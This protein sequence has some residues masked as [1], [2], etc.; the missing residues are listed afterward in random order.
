MLFGRVSSDDDDGL[1]TIGLG[2]LPRNCGAGCPYSPG[3]GHPIAVIT[4]K[5]STDV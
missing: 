4:P 1:R 5:A 2:G 3:H